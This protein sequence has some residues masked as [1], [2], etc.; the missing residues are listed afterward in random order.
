MNDEIVGLF[1]RLGL[2]AYE[3][4]A[5]T[6][7]VAAGRP[8]NGY[9]VAKHSGVP[10]STV[11]QTLSRLVARS[12]AFEVNG[13][14]DNSVDYL[15]LPPSTL[16]SRLRDETE[17]AIETVRPLLDKLAVAP[18]M[19][20]TH[21]VADRAEV[22]TRARDVI[23][24]ADHDLLMFIWPEELDDLEPTLRRAERSGT[25]IGMVFFGD[26]DGVGHSFRQLLATPEQ[27]AQGLGCRLLVVV[28]DREEVLIAGLLGDEARG[29]TTDSPAIVS[30][31]AEFVRFDILMQRWAS[32]LEP[33]AIEL[34]YTTGSELAFLQSFAPAAALLR[35]LRGSA[36]ARE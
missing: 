13:G 21:S 26:G 8:M 4:K 3:S 9:E 27:V 34:F 25:E 6:A 17:H 12:L 36:E 11:Y 24:S 33:A 31:A 32:K 1:R 35:L 14:E 10:R 29:I 28:S 30:L 22:L 18:T 16:F 20:F 19:H 7:L 2:T 15:P 5:Y 23:S